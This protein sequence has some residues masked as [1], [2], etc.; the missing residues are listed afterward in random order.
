MNITSSLLTF[1]VIAACVCPFA[2]GQQKP[3]E[4]PLSPVDAAATMK[5]PDGF[6]VSLFAGEPDVMQPIGFC[7]DD[8]GRLWV[9]EAYNYPRRGN[10]SGDRIVVFED[11]D[12]DG[13]HDKRTVFYDKLNYVSGI[14][15]GFGGVWVMSP[16]NMY[17]IPDR[18][19]DDVPDGEPEVLLDGFGAHANAHNMANAFAWGPDGWLYATHGRTNWSLVGK[20]GTPDDQRM[21]ID[22]GV[23][24]YHP[25]RHTWENY[26]D[27]TTNPWGIDWNDYGHAFITN[28]VNPHL[29]QVIQGAHYEPWRGRKSSQYAYQ[30][31][32]TI[33]DHLH[34]VGLQNVR[35]GLG[36]AAEDAAGGGH[37]HCGCMVYLG[38]QF[39]SSYRN[40]LF[41]NNIH[42]KRINNDLLR[43]SGSGYIASHGSDLMRSVDDWFMGVLLQY[44]PN[45]EVYVIDWSD[46]GECHS[47]RN[48]QR[49][50]G[51]IY[52]ISYLEKTLPSVNLSSKTTDELVALQMHDNDWMVRHARRLLHERSVNEDLSDAEKQLHARFKQESSIPK[53]LRALWALHTIGKA[54]AE[55]LHNLLSH[56]DENIRSWAIALL[57]QHKVVPGHT[58]QRLT[59]MAASDASSLVR[60]SLCSYL[61]QR[62][63]DERWPI[64]EQLVVHSEDADDQN[65]PSMIWYG[66]EPLINEDLTRFAKLTTTAKLSRIRVNVARRATEQSTE[67]LDAVCRSLQGSRD[68]AVDQDVLNGIQQ[69]LESR[70]RVMLPDSW[71]Q[72]FQR[73]LNSPDPKVRELAIEVAVI[74]HDE[75]AIEL[76]KRRVSNRSEQSSVRKS[77]VR[78]LSGNTVKEFGAIL[79]GELDDRSL[80]ATAMKHLANYDA[81]Q[82]AESILKIYRELSDSEK[83]IATATLSSRPNW[84]RQ[85][86]NAIKSGTVNPSDLTAFSARQVRA[87]GDDTLSDQLTELWGEVRE[88]ARDRKRQIDKLAQWLTPDTI[89]SADLENGK[90]MYG[91]HCASCHKFFGQG[92][93]IGPDI[94]GAQ[95]TNTVYMLE[96]IIDPSAS[97]SKD[98]QVQIIR[99]DDGRVIT[100]LVQSESDEV[101]VVQTTQQRIVVAKSDIEERRLSSESMMPS[102]LL[103]TM[104]EQQIRDLFGYL[105]R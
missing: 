28:C 50:T 58:R 42:G 47:T 18:D 95:R 65:L 22:G 48:T 92:G 25:V 99:T 7:I 19:E 64:A 83:R 90:A 26:A 85:M 52:R 16:P 32:D 23:W 71:Q 44:G 34:F 87:L 10:D 45:G 86:L 36:S 72:P 77:A 31:I 53:K 14:E 11:T 41:T 82:T 101:V 105:Q 20:P 68:A 37:A 103:E 9:A 6:R 104:S 35:N 27:G 38:N 60:L 2:S 21:R 79:L 93:D 97:V 73:L 84:A 61:Q 43:R 57:S 91:K 46:T 4:G 30:R 100:G 62:P 80:R 15:V 17:F 56:S 98:Y 74:G 29:F 59:T 33:A 51:R 102:G 89:S 3:E 88:T 96:N 39:P 40:Q 5:V 63:L 75:N 8:R 69:G 70:R 54:D 66:I 94:T 49:Q 1:A 76:L 55:W 24:R 13:Q 67:G 78:V 12:G 81:P